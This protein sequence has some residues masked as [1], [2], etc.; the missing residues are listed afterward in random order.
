[1]LKKG[2]FFQKEVDSSL[3]KLTN[4]TTI[5]TWT[6]SSSALCSS[7]TMGPNVFLMS[8]LNFCFTYVLLEEVVSKSAFGTLLI[9]IHI[10]YKIKFEVEGFRMRFRKVFFP[11]VK[12]IELHHMIRCTLY[13]ES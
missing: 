1:M 10:P 6:N 13:N 8:N 11:I 12:F 4:K 5:G 3:S 2:R 9:Q 7:Y